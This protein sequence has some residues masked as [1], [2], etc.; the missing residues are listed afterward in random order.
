[1]PLSDV[2]PSGEICG[3]AGN[4]AAFLSPFSIL[5]EPQGSPLDLS[6]S[7][8]SSQGT[9]LKAKTNFAADNNYINPRMRRHPEMTPNEAKDVKYWERR[10]RNNAAARRS[11]QCRRAREAD[12]VEYAAQLE[13][14]NS[15][16]EAEICLLRVQ[17]AN[18]KCECAKLEGAIPFSPIILQ[19]KYSM[20]FRIYTAQSSNPWITSP[21]LLAHF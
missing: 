5:V 14:K 17:L 21:N 15:A 12:L 16:L 19:R 3:H 18:A 9:E 7:Y 11:R 10:C 4:Y 6:K 8:L 1:M 13:R 2:A 20:N